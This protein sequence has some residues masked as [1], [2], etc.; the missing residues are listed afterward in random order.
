M[1]HIVTV[2]LLITTALLPLKAQ[3]VI[4]EF[5][6]ANLSD[7]TDDFGEYEDWI[8][9]YNAGSTAVNLDGYYLS[10]KMDNPT[11][12]QFPAVSIAAN[13]YLVVFASKR[14]ITTG[15]LHANFQLT[16]TASDEAV[17]LADPSG[18]IIDFYQIY[19][20]NQLNHSTGRITSGASQ[21]GV[22]TNP[23]PYAAN[24]GAKNGYAP[25]PD[26]APASGNYAAAQTVTITASDPSVSIYYTTNGYTPTAASTLYTGPIAVSATTVVRAIAVSPDPN[27]LPGFVETN[28]YLIAENH[29][30]PV[31]SVAGAGVQTLLDGDWGSEPIG[32][33][34]LFGE[35]GQL[36]D[37]AVGEFNKHGN[38]SWAYDQRGFDYI[39]RD[40]VGY[41]NEVSSLIFPTYTPRNQFQRLIIKAAA[42]DN[43]PFSNGGAHIRDAYVHA[44]SQ[45]AHLDLDERTYEPCIVYLNGQYWGVYEIRE[46]ADDHDYTGYYYDQGKEWIDYI[47][48]WGATWEEYGSWDDWYALH[49][50]ILANDMT[51]PANY[52]YVTDRLNVQSII[53]YMIINTHVVCMDWLVWNTAWWRG[54]KDEGVKWRYTLWD[55]DATFGHYI[56]YTGIPDTSPF[57]DPCYNEDPNVSDPE[58]HVDLVVQLM[59]NPDFHALYVNRYAQLNNSYFTCDY[60]IA[61][62]DSLVDRIEP[63]MP[64]QVAK[65]GGTMT[66]WQNNV[67][68]LRDFINT[69]CTV[70]DQ[71]IVDCYEVDGPYDITVSVEPPNSGFVSLNSLLLT[72]YPY[73]GTYFGGL[74]L[75]LE[76]IALMGYQFDYWE[77]NNNIV[78]PGITNP[79]IWLNLTSADTIVAHFSVPIPTYNITLIVD[80]PATGTISTGGFEFTT[81]PVNLFLAEGTLIDLLANPASGYQFAGWTANVNTLLPDVNT[82]GISFTLTGND[83]IIAH[84]EEVIPDYNLTINAQPDGAGSISLNGA[85]ITTAL[86]YT[87]TYAEGTEITLSATPQTGFTFAYW[88]TGGTILLP[89]P[90]QSTITLALT[91]NETITAHF[92]PIV[93]E[94]TLTNANPNAGTVTVNGTQVSN[95][96][97]TITVGY[98]ETINLEALA[99]QGFEFASWTLNGTTQTAATLSVTALENATIAINFSAIVVPP[100]PPP[101]EINCEPA[102]PSAFSPNSDG[103]NDVFSLHLNPACTIDGFVLRVFDRW[104]NMVFETTN[105]Q[106]GWDGINKGANCLVGT[107]VWYMQY[108]LVNEAGSV[109]KTYKGNVTLI[110]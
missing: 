110:R 34:E 41:D 95:W 70:I 65:W 40:E 6:A 45:R 5:S 97:Y 52:N 71:G 68:A 25:T 69:R 49:D 28:T 56:N 107:Y 26:I 42:N 89:N 18:T 100:P 35:N 61:L 90:Q 43:Y 96:P 39:T 77:V 82:P 81:Y 93:F 12:W 62:L 55:M 21:W 23:T 73:T 106:R 38:D 2:L 94:I 51:V 67:Q 27:I 36:E 109:A 63:E 19:K 37:E 11:K 80:P 74:Q 105:P 3:V 79:D 47:K 32:S 30:I 31:I 7:L 84:F 33:F 14:D 1:K 60:M 10:D 85:D 9:L 72:D 64:R 53:D 83:T 58:D 17:V 20:P 57:A 78:L 44:L 29:T 59:Q 91:G 48:T 76:A 98:G 108:N 50:Y 103:V 16:Q 46:K 87:G 102:M 101:A 22:F 4:N 13:G 86:P 104:G 24:T 88:E 99:A 66:G 54:R 8:E 15:T 75:D 92:E